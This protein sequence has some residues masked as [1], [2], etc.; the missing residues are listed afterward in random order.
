MA[1]HKPEHRRLD[2]YALIYAIP[3]AIL[4][5]LCVVMSLGVGAISLALPI[6]WPVYILWLA[7]NV[8]I[9]LGFTVWFYFKWRFVTNRQGF[10]F[11]LV[12]GGM[13]ALA[14]WVLG[15]LL[16]VFLPLFTITLLCTAS[17][18]NHYSGIGKLVDWTINVAT[19]G[20][21]FLAKKGAAVAIEKGVEAGVK[22]AAQKAAEKGVAQAGAR[23]ATR[24]GGDAAGG[25]I[26]AG[27]LRGTAVAEQESSQA[28]LQGSEEGAAKAGGNELTEEE[29]LL[30][31]PETPFEKMQRYFEEIPESE[32]P[33]EEEEDE[34]GEGVILEDDQNKVDL[35]KP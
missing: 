9:I 12:F 26:A 14:V 4:Y 28:A 10:S 13:I 25:R 19:L 24:L 20:A 33:P 21:G 18:M 17:L 22:R 2:V 32:T 5:D 1:D 15:S 7:V 31:E 8:L 29:K 23:T 11:R 16:S 3:G 35:R 27:E 34:N 6:F 30:W